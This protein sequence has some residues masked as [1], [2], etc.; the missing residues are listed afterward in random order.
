MNG[1]LSQFEVV[2]QNAYATTAADFVFAKLIFTSTDGTVS[3]TAS[4]DL[5]G[6][7]GP[8]YGAAKVYCEGELLDNTVFR[9]TQTAG[10]GSS[11]GTFQFYMAM[12]SSPGRSWL[13]PTICPGDTFTYTG[14]P[15]YDSEPPGNWINPVLG[16]DDP[17]TTFALPSQGNVWVLIGR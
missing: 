8:F 9:I 16:S 7:S 15:V 11:N 4:N 2:S 14:V 13:V 1:N 5:A 17:Q 10:Q 3:Q 6:S 12:P